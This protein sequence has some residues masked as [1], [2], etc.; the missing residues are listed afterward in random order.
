LG[1]RGTEDPK[2]AGSI[3]A[4]GTISEEIIEAKMSVENYNIARNKALKSMTLGLIF[5]LFLPVGI[6]VS[7]IIIPFLAGRNGAKE[8]PNN[9]H[10]TY[11]LTVGGGWSIGLVVCLIL[12]LSISLGPALRINLAETIIFIVMILFTWASFAI[13]VQSSRIVNAIDLNRPYEEEWKDEETEISELA[14]PKDENPDRSV[15]SFQKVKKII[16]GSKTQENKPSG[17]R[18]T[19]KGTKPKKTSKSKANR[20]SALASRRRK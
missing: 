13:G 12:L 9:W 2:V 14:V 5:L 19:K 10:L 18:E 6:P 7:L 16:Q 17:K 8:L 20:V 11:I 1:E 4:G 15:S 3:P